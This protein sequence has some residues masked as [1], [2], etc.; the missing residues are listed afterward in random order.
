MKEFMFLIRNLGDSKS[1]WS[2]EIHGEFLKAC[3][4]YI[5]VLE[6]ERKLI[7][8]QPLSREG[9]VISGSKVSLIESP[10]N[11]KSEIQVGYYHIFAKDLDEA[12]AIAKRNPEFEYTTTAKIEVRPIKTAEKTTGFVYPKSL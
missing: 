11:E 3:E 2:P 12:I 1:Q 8:A 4:A 7:A 10:I 9:C 5:G 6:T